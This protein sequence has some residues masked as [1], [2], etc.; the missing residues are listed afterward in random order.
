MMRAGT[1]RCKRAVRVFARSVRRMLK[2]TSDRIDIGTVVELGE[3]AQMIWDHRDVI[4]YPVPSLSSERF[5]IEEEIREGLDLKDTTP[6]STA[7]QNK[8][9]SLYEEKMNA[10]P[11][12]YARFV[13]PSGDKIWYIAECSRSDSD[14]EYFG[15]VV[16]HGDAYFLQSELDAVGAKQDETFVPQLLSQ[17]MPESEIV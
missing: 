13:S 7:W 8:L 16:G 15:F 6:G 5:V 4:A 17:V 11:M 9:P 3:P 12:V 10:D 14:F 1:Y 2:K